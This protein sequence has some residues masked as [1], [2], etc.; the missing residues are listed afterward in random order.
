M[1]E[2]PLYDPFIKISLSLCPVLLL[3]HSTGPPPAPK[4][5]ED[6]AHVGAI[7]L[8][9]EPSARYISQP[10]GEVALQ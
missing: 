4:M 3:H 7:G 9:L 6:P 10:G 1:S 8:T 5:S 2:V